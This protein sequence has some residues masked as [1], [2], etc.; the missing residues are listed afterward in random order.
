MSDR[1]R[2]RERIAVLESEQP[3][4]VAEFTIREDAIEAL[5]R[6]LY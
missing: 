1:E 3:K 6:N 5:L 4:N 2:I